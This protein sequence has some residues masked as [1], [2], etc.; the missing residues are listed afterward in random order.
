MQMRLMQQQLPRRRQ[1][2]RVGVWAEDPISVFI[3]SELDGYKS[4]EASVSFSV[5][6]GIAISSRLL[7]A[8]ESISGFLKF[9][10]TF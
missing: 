7:L 5:L 1:Q 3:K 2:A 8:M 4:A 10:V 6:H 9:W